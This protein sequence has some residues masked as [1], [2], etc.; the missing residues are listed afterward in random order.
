METHISFSTLNGSMSLSLR[1]TLKVSSTCNFGCDRK[2]NPLMEG[3][4]FSTMPVV[5]VKRLKNEHEVSTIIK[6]EPDLEE[7]RHTNGSYGMPH[8]TGTKTS[9]DKTG[10]EV[11]E[12][13]SDSDS[14]DSDG[15]P[16][17]IIILKTE[18][19]SVEMSNGEKLKKHEDTTEIP[20]KGGPGK[21]SPLPF[22]PSIFTEESGTIWTDS[23][24]TSYAVDGFFL[25]TKEV[26][27]D[28]V[29][30]LSNIPCVWPIPKVQTA[31]ILDLR[32]DAK[33]LVR[34]KVGGNGATPVTPDFLLKNMVSNLA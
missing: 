7:Q 10:H 4:S 16:S 1:Y 20:K 30:Y 22:D 18:N 24:V 34:K 19:I 26:R 11:I 14:E 25:V 9:R 13:L 2:L 8:V 31:F 32:D 28:R 27:V 33:Y 3:Q 21:R 23:D 6:S 17:G 15:R 12:I 29:E 5:P